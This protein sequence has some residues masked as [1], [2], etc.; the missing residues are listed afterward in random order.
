[1]G[2]P[3]KTAALDRQTMAM[4]SSLLV[5]AFVCAATAI[6]VS[7]VTG[8]QNLIQ[9]DVVSDVNALASSSGSLATETA[10]V[11][12]EVTRAITGA[13]AEVATKKQELQKAEAEK[14]AEVQKM[15]AVVA[16]KKTEADSAVAQEKAKATG[17]KDV[18]GKYKTEAQLAVSTFQTNLGALFDTLKSS[19]GNGVMQAEL[20]QLLQISGDVVDDVKGLS[21]DASAL[22]DD[23]RKVAQSVKSFMTKKDGDKK[24]MEDKKAKA[25]ADKK[26]EIDKVISDVAYKSDVAG[27][28][29][30]AVKAKVGDGQVSVV[31]TQGSALAAVDALKGT[32]TGIFERMKTEFTPK[33]A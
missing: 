26:E 11:A 10:Q 3:G 19:V 8:L 17:V 7:N 2:S 14:D 29:I 30:A 6:P 4:Y 16:A 9:G 32:L 22:S 13:E 12:D 24:G 23:T 25:E 15:E 20:Q 33:D 1:M 5:A 18:V 27:K 28:E 31:Q 21:K